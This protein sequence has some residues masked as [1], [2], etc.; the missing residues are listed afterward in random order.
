MIAQVHGSTVLAITEGRGS[1]EGAALP[2]ADGLVTNLPGVPLTIHLADCLSLFVLDPGAPAIG[3][4]HAGWRGTVQDIGG[5]VV[6][7]MKRRYG[8]DPAACLAGIGPGL[9]PCCFLVDEDV[10]SVFHGAFPSWEDL[11]HATA[12]K[13]SIDLA[14]VNRRLLCRAGL[15]D[16]QIASGSLCTS[17]RA[18][19]FFSYRRDGRVTGRMAATLVLES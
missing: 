11:I 8:T 1:Q 10:A 3:L 14:E 5:A 6:R 4:A 16:G 15:K 19:L 13:W 7:E 12:N 9:G 2:E 17:C 18:D